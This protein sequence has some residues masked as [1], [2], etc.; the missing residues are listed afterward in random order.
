M[1]MDASSRICLASDKGVLFIPALNKLP[2]IQ[3]PK[4]CLVKTRDKASPTKDSDTATKAF[5]W[6]FHHKSYQGYSENEK[7]P[8]L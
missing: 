8:N 7:N 5:F 4:I 1:A 2:C 6:A 3:Y